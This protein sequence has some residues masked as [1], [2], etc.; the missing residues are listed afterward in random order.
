M[1]VRFGQ[2]HYENKSTVH[3]LMM[4][5]ERKTLAVKLLWRTYEQVKQPGVHIVGIQ[6]RLIPFPSRNNRANMKK[7]GTE[8][9]NLQSQHRGLR[10][11]EVPNVRFPLSC[12]E[13]IT[14]V[15]NLPHCQCLSTFL[16]G[17]Q[18]H[19][20][21][22][23]VPDPESEKYT[24]TNV[25]DGIQTAFRKLMDDTWVSPT[26]EVIEISD[27][28]NEGAWRGKNTVLADLKCM[29]WKTC[30]DE[31][32]SSNTADGRGNKWANVNLPT[33]NQ[34]SKKKW[35]TI[36]SRENLPWSP[37]IYGSWQD[38]H[39]HT[40]GSKNVR[41]IDFNSRKSAIEFFE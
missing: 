26:V 31:T 4:T 7:V 30:G 18:L 15:E 36:A 40:S 14:L 41:F 17:K 22:M 29:T 32:D 11:I 12:E 19:Y 2:Y 38:C 20:V 25:Q 16:V 6:V 13:E 27:N 5:L 33:M 23:V 10:A 35:Y 34:R 9:H 1:G 39:R 8:V 28:E 24:T 3:A 21:V 37:G